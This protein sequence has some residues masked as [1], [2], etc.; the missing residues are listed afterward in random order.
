MTRKEKPSIPPLPPRAP[1][2]ARA[3]YYE[4]YSTQELLAAGHLEEVGVKKY[5]RKTA[6]L[7][8]RVEK[9]LLTQLKQAAKRKRLPLSTLVR[10]WLIERVQ[11]N[12][13]A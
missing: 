9:T 5:P 13:V 11:E 10:M 2:E 12:Q 3:R 1:Y 4:Q 8:F 6:T 7:S